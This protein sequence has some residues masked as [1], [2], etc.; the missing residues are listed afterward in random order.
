MR[1]LI[2]SWILCANGCVNEIIIKTVIF[3]KTTNILSNNFVNWKHASKRMFY[4]WLN[5]YISGRVTT[6]SGYNLVNI[7]ESSLKLCYRYYTIRQ[8]ILHQVI[9][10]ILHL[11]WVIYYDSYREGTFESV[12]NLTCVLT[13]VRLLLTFL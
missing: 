13:R 6:R 7:S 5:W 8:Q 2:A 1:E 11:L 9:F 4:F 3:N 12:L 10:S